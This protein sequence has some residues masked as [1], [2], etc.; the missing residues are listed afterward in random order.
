MIRNL[1]VISS[2]G[3]VLCAGAVRFGSADDETKKATKSD[4]KKEIRQDSKATSSKEPHDEKADLNS[5]ELRRTSESYTEAFSK[6]D[7]RAILEH[8]AERAEYVDP[9]GTVYHGKQEI[10]KLLT[11]FFKDHPKSQLE[12]DIGDIRTVGDGIAVEDGA[13]TIR[14]GDD[15]EDLACEYTAFH[16]KIDGKW[17]TVSV[18]ERKPDSTPTHSAQ[19]RQMHWL[20]GEWV[21]EGDEEVAY[22]SCEPSDNGNFLMRKFAVQITGDDVISGTQRIGWDAAAGKLRTWVFDSEGGYGDGYWE[23]S[24]NDWIL[25]L[26]G[27]TKDGQTASCTSIYSPIDAN[28]MVFQA[29]DHQIGDV[30]VPD[31]EPLTIVR[32]SPQPE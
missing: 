1:A 2:I 8:F 24:G 28:T 18:R 31:T 3:L 7:V 27:V 5:A 32:Q 29:V 25:K 17:L 14:M 10:E 4:A 15:T 11:E 6:G 12:L 30:K 21:H 23:R 13:S 22:F 9:E 16:Q 20:L 26:S 19:L